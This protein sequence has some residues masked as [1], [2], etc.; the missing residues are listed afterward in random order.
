MPANAAHISQRKCLQGVEVL[1]GGSQSAQVSFM[2]FLF[3]ALV[4]LCNLGDWELGYKQLCE[5]EDGL[6]ALV[7]MCG[8]H[9]KARPALAWAALMCAMQNTDGTLNFTRFAHVLSRVAVRCVSL[10][11]SDSFTPI[12]GSDGMRLCCQHRLSVCT[13]W[14]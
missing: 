11:G 3:D 14:P 8:I 1:W 13:C 5:Q 4:H 7:Y 2:R 12:V 10:F 9:G 6:S